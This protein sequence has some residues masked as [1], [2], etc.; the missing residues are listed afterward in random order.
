MLMHAFTGMI[1]PKLISLSSFIHPAVTPNEY[2]V[3]FSQNTKRKNNY[4]SYFPFKDSS[5]V[6][7]D[8]ELHECELTMTEISLLVVYA[9]Y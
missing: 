3:I 6:H 8:L 7:T 1:H 5:S 4:C 2:T 9:S